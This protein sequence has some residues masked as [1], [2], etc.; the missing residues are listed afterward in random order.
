VLPSII[1]TK[2]KVKQYHHHHHHHHNNN[3]TEYRIP[4][5]KKMMSP[6]RKKQGFC[7]LAVKPTS[8]PEQT[9]AWLEMRFAIPTVLCYVL[10]SEFEGGIWIDARQMFAIHDQFLEFSSHLGIFFCRQI[11]EIFQ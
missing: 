1:A 6:R 3:N 8:R 10:V 2:N 4:Q 11:D 9:G 5:K 7:T